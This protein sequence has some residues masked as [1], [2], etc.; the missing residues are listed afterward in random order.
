[1][2]HLLARGSEVVHRWHLNRPQTTSFHIV[3]FMCSLLP[4]I[5]T[6]TIDSVEKKKVVI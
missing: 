4:S 6:Y 2:G 3:V 1:M 5:K